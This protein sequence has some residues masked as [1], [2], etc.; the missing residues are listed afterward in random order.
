MRYTPQDKHRFLENDGLEDDFIFFQ[1]CI[2]RV[3]VKLMGCINLSNM[4]LYTIAQADSV[5][6]QAAPPNL[7]KNMCTSN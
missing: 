1:G 6:L 7:K 4:I 3:N 2:L 5:G